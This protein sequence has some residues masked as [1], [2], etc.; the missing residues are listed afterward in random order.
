MPNMVMFG[1]LTVS[2][3]LGALIPFAPA[4]YVTFLLFG[5]AFALATPVVA[6]LAA[7]VLAPEARAEGFGIYY[8]WYFAGMPVLLALAGALRDWTG[9][10]TVSVLFATGLVAC[11]VAL[12]LVL[13]GIHRPRYAT[14]R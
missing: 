9:K 2:I 3:L 10:A 7:Q 14:G 11:C 6:S 13:R 5:V 12:V 8:L 1:G 4:P